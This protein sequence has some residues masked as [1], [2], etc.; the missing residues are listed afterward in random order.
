MNLDK[1]LRETYGTA[2]ITSSMVQEAL[3][4]VRNVCE[5]AMSGGEAARARLVRC[6]L[7]V[8]Q[9]TVA[10]IDAVSNAA[11]DAMGDEARCKDLAQV[12]V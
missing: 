9:V 3:L 11:F 1:W 12:S 10:T 8:G 2:D 5:C 6:G 4:D 7:I